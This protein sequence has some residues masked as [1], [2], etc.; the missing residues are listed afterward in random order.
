[1]QKNKK[2]TLKKILQFSKINFF[3]DLENKEFAGSLKISKKFVIKQRK[4]FTLLYVLR[5]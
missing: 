1:M 4:Q 3:Q 2:S 5:K